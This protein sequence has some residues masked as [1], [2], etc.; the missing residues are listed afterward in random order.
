[1][2][3]S[4]L[5][6]ELVSRKGYPQASVDSNVAEPIALWRV[7]IAILLLLLAAASGV[8][9]AYSQKHQS[10][11]YITAP[12]ER[13][14]VAAVVAAT[15]TVNPI[16]TAHVSSQLSGRVTEVFVS[17]NDTVTAGQLLG[18]L[19]PEIFAA[20]VHEARAALKIAKSA[21]QVQRAWLAR[22]KAA[23]AAAR[24]ARTA[25]EE[26]LIGLKTKLEETERQ[27]L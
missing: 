16:S 22:T 8:S 2:T 24:T 12:I 23:L 5:C 10:H 9:Y 1:L 11:N 19:D 26:N 13:G 17:L 21:V 15:G 4:K 7:S 20:R 6:L 18:R 3:T 25:T 14:T 27:L